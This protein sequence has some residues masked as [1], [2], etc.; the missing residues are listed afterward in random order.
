MFD[1]RNN[2]NIYFVAR[3]LDFELL[4][5]KKKINVKKNQLYYVIACTYIINVHR[6]AILFGFT[7]N[8]HYPDK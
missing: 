1:E 7:F 2:K 6:G 3:K 8:F 4:V 5:N